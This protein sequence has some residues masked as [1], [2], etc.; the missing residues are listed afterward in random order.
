MSVCMYI[1]CVCLSVCLLHLSVC[2]PAKTIC[3]CKT[4]RGMKSTLDC[5]VFVCAWLRNAPLL[6]GSYNFLLA[7]TCPAVPAIFSSLWLI[8]SVLHTTEAGV[9]GKLLARSDLTAGVAE[10]LG[11]APVR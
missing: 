8:D 6:T 3:F 9:P 11:V 1:C 10:S 4:R 7:C 5:C 2:V